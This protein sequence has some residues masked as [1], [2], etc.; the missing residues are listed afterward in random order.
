[1]AGDL[2]LVHSLGVKEVHGDGYEIL[3]KN[4]VEYSRIA[5]CLEGEHGL[6]EEEK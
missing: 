2:T 4:T 5:P 3:G 6:S 1:M